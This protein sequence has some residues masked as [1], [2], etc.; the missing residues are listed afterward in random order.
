MQ[1][2]FPGSGNREVTDGPDE[3][4]VAGGWVLAQVGRRMPGLAGEEVST[5]QPKGLGYEKG[6][7][8]R[9]ANGQEADGRGKS[10]QNRRR[11]LRHS[12]KWGRLMAGNEACGGYFSAG[13]KCASEALENE[14]LVA[15]YVVTSATV[16][17]S[18]IFDDATPA[19]REGARARC[20]EKSTNQDTPTPIVSTRVSGFRCPCGFRGIPPA[21]AERPVVGL[22]ALG[23]ARRGPRLERSASRP[24]G[25]FRGGAPNV[26]SGRGAGAARGSPHSPPPGVRGGRSLVGLAK[27][28]GPVPALRRVCNPMDTQKCTEEKSRKGRVKCREVR[29]EAT[30]RRLFC[31]GCVTLPHHGESDLCYSEVHLRRMKETKD[32]ICT[33][34][35]NPSRSRSI[36][37]CEEEKGDFRNGM[38]TE[39]HRYLE[40]QK[41]VLWGHLGGSVG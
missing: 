11:H 33:P 37:E 5:T 35:C 23:R 26:D 41:K 6:Q 24:S 12:P 28:T 17:S 32:C 34:H 18:A 16:A 22:D 3:S 29:H 36:E 15:S 7:E 8:R 30:R 13:V 10:G 31:K 1:N 9:M 2:I 27:R 21:G 20:S 14:S 39:C 4:G 25:A 19:R 38:M 40:L